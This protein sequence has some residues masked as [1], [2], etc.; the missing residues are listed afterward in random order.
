MALN[1]AREVLDSVLWR[2]HEEDIK[3]E[4][5]E[6]SSHFPA[7]FSYILQ[8]FFPEY[9]KQMSQLVDLLLCRR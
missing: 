4:K 8:G 9:S 7:S 5:G 3:L 1:L 6:C 2:Y